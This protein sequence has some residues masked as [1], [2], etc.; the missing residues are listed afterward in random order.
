MEHG[1]EEP[2]DALARH[3][4]GGLRLRRAPASVH[5]VE[6]PRELRGGEAPGRVD[7]LAH[8]R[9]AVAP[10]ER[11]EE[12]LPCFGRCGGFGRAA[13]GGG[14]R[15]AQRGGGGSACRGAGGDEYGRRGGGGVAAAFDGVLW[16]VA[17]RLAAARGRSGRHVGGWSG[18]GG[19]AEEEASKV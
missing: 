12:P 13:H 1:L 19:R 17:A 14:A 4:E 6:A 2:V 18:R 11:V 7:G 8:G 5:N 15:G 16:E 3:G 10:L 9:K